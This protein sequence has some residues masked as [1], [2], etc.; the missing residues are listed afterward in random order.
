MPELPEVETVRR[1]LRPAL[2]GR[3]VERAEVRR[4]GL[5]WPFPE[6][7]AERLA[8]AGV[9][10]VGRRAKVLLVHLDTGET[11]LVHLGMTGRMRVD[12]RVLGEYVHEAG[13]TPHDHIVLHLDDGARV[14][15]NDA[16]RFGVVD[17]WPTEALATHRLLAGLGPEP[18][19]VGFDGGTLARGFRGR[20]A[21]VK[22]LLLDGRLVAGIGNIYA[23]E[24]LAR[25]GIHPARAAGRIGR[26][27]LDRLAGA[28]RETLAEAIEAG[29]STLQDHRR[30]DGTAGAFQHRF[31]AYD[32]DGHPCG[33]GGTIRRIVQGGRSTFYC[34]GCQR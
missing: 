32:R 5:R 31:R 2:L 8:G 6:R 26:A 33:C 23:S 15:F 18:L 22:P 12:D 3:R 21:P 34:P 29:G 13:G 1:G 24:A 9:T 27:R 19:E 11:L 30:T 28:I 7:L 4:A 16:R 10:E 14:T 20:A 17:L 25:A